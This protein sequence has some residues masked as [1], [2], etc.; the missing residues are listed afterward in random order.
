[1]ALLQMAQ[2]GELE[3]KIVLINKNTNENW[4]KLYGSF[5]CQPSR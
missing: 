1:M 2:A 3:R 4:I 5:G